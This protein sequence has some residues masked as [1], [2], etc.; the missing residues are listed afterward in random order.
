MIPIQQLFPSSLKDECTCLLI[1]TLRCSS[2]VQRLLAPA[3]KWWRWTR[4]LEQNPLSRNRVSNNRLYFLLWGWSLWQKISQTQMLS[5]SLVLN[6]TCCSPDLIYLDVSKWLPDVSTDRQIL[7][8]WSKL[9][10]WST[11]DKTERFSVGAS[12]YW[13]WG[14][15]DFK[16][17]WK[18]CPQSFFWIQ[19][20]LVSRI[21][22]QRFFQWTHSSFADMNLDVAS[23]AG[24]FSCAWGSFEKECRT[25]E[26]QVYLNTD[27]K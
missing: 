14:S 3:L 4:V 13:Q 7:C 6:M 11:R 8:F 19:W 24:D 16:N 27:T 5:H 18:S 2:W 26:A 20:S 21:K 12:C 10:W 9:C 25:S 1:W 23:S 22:R 15:V 17:G